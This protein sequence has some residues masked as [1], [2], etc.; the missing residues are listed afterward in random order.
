MESLQNLLYAAVSPVFLSLCVAALIWIHLRDSINYWAKR[1]IP[2]IPAHRCL[3]LLL[4][5]KFGWK[6]DME[7]YCDMYN[8]LEGHSYG[9][10][11]EVLK[12]T[13]ILRDPAMVNAWLVKGFSSFRDH[14]S[15][16]APDEEGENLTGELFALTGDRWRQ[17]RSKLTPLFSPAKL[18]LMYE[19][20]KECTEELKD[21][22]R[23]TVDDEA[24][25]EIKD[26]VSRHA[27]D[28]IGACA[29]GVKCNA[30]KD[31]ENCV[32]MKVANRVL[33]VGWRSSV[34]F[35]LNLV[36]PRLPHLLGFSLRSPEVVAFMTSLTKDVMRMKKE[37]EQPSQHFLRM[38]MDSCEL[39]EEDIHGSKTISLQQE[40]GAEQ[41]ESFKITEDYVA[42]VF[43]S[44]L[45]A[46]LEPISI[47]VTCCFYE[48][49]HHPEIQDRIFNEIQ[50]IKEGSG[51]DITFEDLKKLQYLEQVV[52]ETLR[53][54]PT[55]GF[56]HRECTEPFHIPDSSIVVEKGVRLFIST[57]GLHRDPKYFPEPDKFDPDRFSK[58]NIHKIVPGSYLPFGEGPRVCVGKQLALMNIKH[59]VMNLVSDYTLQTCE[60]TQNCL[61]TDPQ[62]FFLGP[63]GEVWLRLKKRK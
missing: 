11:F 9:G 47:I 2:H 3:V 39:Q 18:K 37:S 7:M 27:M 20:L 6:H 21:H 17:V 63:K 59:M 53:K 52:K 43:A 55:A 62:K 26:V 36:H 57:C 13:I 56:I 41:K 10:A 49:A 58:E 33:D 42:G 8:A 46:G 1:G 34:Y 38:L 61:R 45:S 12:P 22:L 4:A 28:V 23:Q 19:T 40:L 50:T 32:I 15:G 48:L 5:E 25:V 29:L 24:D 14:H 60:K 35:F 30:V 16:S 51:S 54:Y 44:F 31:P